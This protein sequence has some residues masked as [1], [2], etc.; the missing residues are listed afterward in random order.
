[1]GN[2]I[3]AGDRFAVS[4][5]I[6]IS[7]QLAFAAGEQVVVE[8]I[9]PN[10]ER[11]EY[12]YVVFSRLLQ[13]RF[14]LSDSDLASVGQPAVSAPP[15]GTTTPVRQVS[16]K[17]GRT[18]TIAIIAGIVA[19]LLVIGL[20]A[21]LLLRGTPQKMFSLGNKSADGA[22]VKNLEF[23]RESDGYYLVGTAASTKD[24][25]LEILLEVSIGPGDT[26]EAVTVNLKADRESKIN[27]RIEVSGDVTACSLSRVKFK[28]DA[29]EEDEGKTTAGGSFST[30][31]AG[32]DLSLVIPANVGKATEIC[33]FIAEAE[34][35]LVTEFDTIILGALT[36]TNNDPARIVNCGD[37][38]LELFFDNGQKVISESAYNYVSYV[39]D[40]LYKSAGH[41]VELIRVGLDLCQDLAQKTSLEPGEQKT[42]Y[43]AFEI[44]SLDGLEDV[45]VSSSLGGE[46][47][48][49]TSI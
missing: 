16:E 12:R 22:T 9:D 23:S 7:G 31:L 45:H 43:F 27:E 37:F 42:D 8:K 49:M 5:D 21:Y 48:P 36:S 17:G 1:M 24:G 20:T 39:T 30:E 34:R 41:E 18:K 2:E 35:A 46:P 10:P 44:E 26:K 28:A 47:V 11:P 40:V 25:K 4:R 6:E 33:A 19:L 32:L 14:Q 29:A 38:Q 3:S 15:A 13:R